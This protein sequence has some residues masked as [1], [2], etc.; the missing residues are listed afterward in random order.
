MTI[1]GDDI[2]KNCRKCWN[3]NSFGIKL[4]EHSNGVYKCP[5]CNQKYVVEN[6]FSKML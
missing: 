5:H 1:V 2:V 3:E 4:V 6:G